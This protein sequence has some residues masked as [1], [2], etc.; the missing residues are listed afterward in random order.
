M[1]LKLQNGLDAFSERTG[2]LLA[3]LPLLLILVQFALVLSVY[4]F[5][6]GNIQ[7][8]ESLQYINALMFLGGAGYTA[9]KDEHVRVD[10]FYSKFSK[11]KKAWI[12]LSGTVFLLLPFLALF[13][14]ATLPY[15]A[16]S[17]AIKE[18]S[19]ESS[20]LPFIYLLKSTLILFALTMTVHALADIIRHSRALFGAR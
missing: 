13:W 17:W 6:I 8:Q 16:D 2:E 1:L 4:V 11:R 19:A 7:L 15:V 12:D 5:S 18:A 14:D 9:L 10:L 20:G 3:V